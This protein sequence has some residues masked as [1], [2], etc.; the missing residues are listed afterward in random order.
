MYAA[1][2]DPV[3]RARRQRLDRLRRRS[4]VYGPQ[5]G[6]QRSPRYRSHR[7][8]RHSHVGGY[9]GDGYSAWEQDL[10]G[11][12]EYGLDEYAFDPYF[13]SY[14]M[15]GY[16]DAM[17]DEEFA[18]MGHT[19]W[20][21]AGGCNCGEFH[22]GMVISGDSGWTS[23]TGCSE[24]QNGTVESS[25]PTPMPETVTPQVFESTTGLQPMP[26]SS[27]QPISLPANSEDF[28]TPRPMPAPT[29]AGTSIESTS[30]SSPV[31]PVLWVPN[32]L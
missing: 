3:Q 11:Y 20:M 21:P 31:Q 6:M 25:S 22:D 23:A 14:G 26:R 5:Y 2:A 29:P 28:Y 19:G 32:G 27:T 17:L 15:V 18:L 7:M 1:S 9:Y 4:M 8:P 30:G 13:D 16:D 12:D 24:C 10:Y